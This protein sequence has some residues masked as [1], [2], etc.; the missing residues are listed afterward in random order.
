MINMKFVTH[1]SLVLTMSLVSFAL[2]NNYHTTS[3]SNTN[4]S[5]SNSNTVR[6]LPGFPGILP[7]NLQTGYIGVWEEQ[8]Q[9]FYY[10][11]K[12]ENNPKA[13]PLLVWFAGG[14]GCSSFT[15]L[16]FGRIGPL[17]FNISSQW[18]DGLPRLESN[19]YSWT[20]VA[21]VL[22]IDSP[23]GAGF[24]YATNKSYIPSDTNTVKQAYEFLKKWLIEHPEFARNPIYIAGASYAGRVISTLMLE[25]INGNE[26]G[27][28][29]RMN[30]QGYIIGN[31]VMDDFV[32]KHAIEYAHRISIL[33]DELYESAKLS[34]HGDYEPIVAEGNAQCKEILEATSNCMDPVEE[35]FILES[36]C[37]VSTPEKW[38]RVYYR[39]RMSQSWANDIN[40]QAALH[41]REGTIS[42][43]F[44]C[45]GRR[46]DDEFKY[47]SDVDNSV[48]YQQNL[49]TEPLRALI[50]S[51]DQDMLAP[52]MTTLAWIKKLNIVPNG[53]YWRPWFLNGQVGGYVTEY[54]NGN[55]NLTFT[56][57]K[58][59]GHIAPEYKSQECLAMLQRWIAFSPL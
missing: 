8:M 10:F 4:T 55:Y 40:V 6:F 19:P 21:N 35:S 51:G 3:N 27:S 32:S 12:S 20:K 25:I 45:R 23:V 16:V 2:S 34:C 15:D 59:A 33:S 54:S 31:P 36:K 53:D 18:E 39:N 48:S 11:L 22:F 5:H 26:A 37:N 14:P 43:W 47:N 57:I 58:G 50:F 30:I 28:E 52:Y 24:S 1:L 41:V 38:C 13:D 44:R 9:L 56:T 46:S 7:F 29:T 49:T 17:S 42:E